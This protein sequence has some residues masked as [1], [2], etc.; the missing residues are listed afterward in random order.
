MV[1]YGPAARTRSCIVGCVL[2]L[3]G[4]DVAWS[5]PQSQ[6]LPQSPQPVPAAAATRGITLDQ[7]IAA[8]LRNDPAYAAAY[9]A[10]GS[11]RLDRALTRGVLLPSAG[12]AGQ[13][14]YTQ[15]NGVRNQAGQIGSQAAPRFIANNAIR[16]YAT[17]L[18]VNENLS[19][20]DVAD[21]SRARALAVQAGADLES[22]RR[23][24]VVRVVAA[25]FEVLSADDKAAVARRAMA[26]AQDFVDLTQKLE[27]GREVAHA[28]VVRAQLDLQQRQR[29][30]A[31]ATLAAAKARLDLG[32]LLFPDPRTAYTLAAESQPFPP[33]P[34]KPAVEAA[35]SR[36]NP[37]LRSALAALEAARNA[38]TAA[39]AAW[40]PSLGFNY[41]YG[42]DAP[43]LAV[44]GPGQVRNLGYSAAVSIDF[45]LWNWLGTHD[46]VKQSQLQEH[47]AQAVLTTTE[48]QLIA[49]LDE[50]Y[51]EARVA[52]DQVASLR[53]SVETARESL[54]LTRLRYQAGEAI[55]LEVVDAETALAQA[56]SALADGL[57][58]SRVARANLQ[59]LTGVL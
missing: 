8:A 1:R 47:A 14:L 12:F 56:E 53:A 11:A 59:T 19:L 31:D 55:A 48:R 58:R 29:E 51:D 35:A 9:A 54:R 39:R 32:V 25:Y 15:P 45:P 57:L 16:E 27:V 7:A 20:A 21:Y 18:L 40:L 37:D 28:D 44:N 3:A 6:S 4:A 22:A 13:Y 46:R 5:A 50:Y 38:V 2:L 41:T 24:L 30:S 10:S 36:S 17:Q 34:D 42:I 33:L 43:Q 23:D 52:G 26:E 49:Q